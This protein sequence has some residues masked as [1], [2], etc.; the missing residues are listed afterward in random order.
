[1]G[2]RD[3]AAKAAGAQQA[4]GDAKGQVVRAETH[5]LFEKVFGEW[6]E[7]LGVTEAAS[8]TITGDRIQGPPAGE[9]VSWIECTT[10]ID[11]IRLEGVLTSKTQKLVMHI[12]GD[13]E[14][15]IDSLVQL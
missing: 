7:R 13:R 2:L 10:E 4:A 5:E 11:G 3:E 6:C 15:R 14:S 12:A 1:M 8:P 9:K